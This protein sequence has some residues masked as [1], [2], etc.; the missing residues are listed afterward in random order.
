MSASRDRFPRRTPAADRIL[1]TAARLFYARGI[2]AIGVDT[3]AA[4]SGVTKKTLYNRFGSK[5]V[6]VAEYLRERD[7]NWR[8]FLEDFVAARSEDPRD[9]IL[10]AYTALAQW[11]RT[12]S[13]RGC[14]FV[15]ANAELPDAEHPGHTVITEHKRW[16]A[17]FFEERARAAGCRDPERIAQD[18]MLIY[19]GA[20]VSHAFNP[21]HK[22]FDRARDLADRILQAAGRGGQR[23]ASQ[24]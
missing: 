16:M 23:C 12:H 22:P 8:D 9:Q 18:L 3:I 6:L 20:L 11:S 5:D 17:E 19:E 1:E 4:E 2:H 13:P 10:D 7:Q 21:G 15:N 24:A 14:S